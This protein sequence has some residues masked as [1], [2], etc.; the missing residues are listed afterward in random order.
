MVLGFHKKLSAEILSEDGLVVLGSGMG[1]DNVF[2][3]FIRLY[4]SSAT[5]IV[6]VLNLP[7]SLQELYRQRMAYHGV[8]SLPRIINNES[9][10]A[11]RY[12]LT[13]ALAL[14]FGIAVKIALCSSADGKCTV[15]D[16]S[17]LYLQGGVLFITSWILVLDLLRKR[18]PLH[19]VSGILVYNAH[20]YVCPR[21]ASVATCGSVADTCHVRDVVQIGGVLYRGI[22]SQA[23]STRKQGLPMAVLASVLSSSRH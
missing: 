16:S 3:R 8:C 14:A 5:H 9:S 10:N 15:L 23:L 1:I 6:L 18:V 11:E 19:V 2:E 20:R 13:L 17:T 7:Q 4:S 21:D 22:H 12:A